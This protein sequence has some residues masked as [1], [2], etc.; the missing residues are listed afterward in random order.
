MFDE[1]DPQ[2][3][4]GERFGHLEADVAGADDR[5]RARAGRK[6]VVE[7]KRLL[8][9]VQQVHGGELE[10]RQVRADGRGARG[11]DESVVFEFSSAVCDALRVGSIR[12]AG[13]SSHSVMPVCS[14]SAGDVR[15][16]V[17]ARD[18]AE[19]R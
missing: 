6:R 3:A 13:S 12:T 1:R 9:G 7:R 2:P 15:E 17:R 18:V 14:R 16:L 4:L 10:T 5:R 19:S 11:D 8:H